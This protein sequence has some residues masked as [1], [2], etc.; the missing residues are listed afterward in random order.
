MHRSWRLNERHY[1]KLQGLNKS[2]TA[3]KFG[4]EQVFTWRRSYATPPP[5]LSLDDPQHPTKDR[6][7]H[8]VP[9][10]DLP[11]SEALKQTLDRFL[12]YW[13]E[14]ILPRIQA[15][16]NVLIVA[17]GNSLRALIKHLDQ[18]S[19]DEISQLNIPT[20]IPLVYE[21]DDSLKPVKNYYLGDPDAA[22]SAANKVAAQAKG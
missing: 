12:P 18:I 1:G 16:E 9:P 8:N 13:N 17:H 19:D 2:E 22:K 21:L 6:R 14:T 4:D 3:E 15:G 10:Q 20:A 7:Y 11:S 5:E